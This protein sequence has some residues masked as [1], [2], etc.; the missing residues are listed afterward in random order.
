[1]LEYL[2]QSMSLHYIRH[3]EKVPF[4][5]LPHSVPSRTLFVVSGQV[6]PTPDIL[7]LQLM[8]QILATF[9]KHY[10]LN[11]QRTNIKC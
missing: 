7:F 6:F 5:Q 4:C 9:A 1:M 11:N 10:H 8:V 3:D 2:Y